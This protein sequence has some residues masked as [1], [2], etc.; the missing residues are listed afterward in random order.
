MKKF[1]PFSFLPRSVQGR[2]AFKKT[3]F[4]LV[5]VLILAAGITL[6]VKNLETIKLIFVGA[7]GNEANIVIQANTV[8]GPMP[9]PWRHLAQ[10]GEDPNWSLSAT[11]AQVQTLHPEYIRIDHLYDFYVTVGRGD[12]GLTFDWSKLDVLVRDM[13]AVGAVPFISLSYTPPIL[14]PEGDITGIPTNWNEYQYVIQR[15]IQHVSGELGVR[16]VA[17]E[18]WNE[19]DLF[20]QWKTYGEKNYLTLYGYAA[21]GADAAAKAGVAPFMFGGPATTAL[22][23]NWVD[24]LLT[25][26][27]EN[28]LRMDF[29]SWHRY[30]LDL[31]KFIEDEEQAAKWVR[32]YP[33]FD[34][35]PL[36]ITEWGHDSNNNAGY[37]GSFGAAHTAA[38]SI[39]MIGNIA[40]A[41]IFEIE[42]GKDPAGQA[43]W[44]RWGLMTH[45]STGSTTKPRFKALQFIDSVGNQRVQITG[46]GTWV[47]AMSGWDGDTLSIVLANYDPFSRHNEVV[48]V[49]INGLTGLRYT[50]QTQSLDGQARTQEVQTE[51]GSYIFSQPMLPNSVVKITLTPGN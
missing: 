50:M 46:S 22:Y 15:T 7:S 13:R 5:P 17:Y 30:S 33:Q 24:Q 4:L 48:P 42:D 39:E 10:G 19:P 43:Y 32:D 16:D 2:N 31:Q 49:T 45:S 8:L 21:R 18:V 11:K 28:N 1:T 3:L 26:A 27:S 40:R 25:Y 20:G 34:G 6:A 47:K 35:L 12:G 29:Y 14:A 9:R 41:F 38:A 23:K 51:Q 36:Y 44:G 37:D